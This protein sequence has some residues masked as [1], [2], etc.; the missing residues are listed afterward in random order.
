[1]TEPE[2]PTFTTLR[3]E[4]DDRIGRLTLTQPGNLNPIGT[5]A[6]LELAEAARWFDTTSASVV[7]VTG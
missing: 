3:V 7:I 5:T 6:L 1:M 4:V 2:V